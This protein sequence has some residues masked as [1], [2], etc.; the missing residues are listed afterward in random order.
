MEIDKDFTGSLFMPKKRFHDLVYSNLIKFIREK[1][2]ILRR[3][4]HLLFFL[5]H[6]GCQF[7]WNSLYCLHT[8]N[9]CLS[10]GQ[11]RL[12]SI[13]YIKREGEYGKTSRQSGSIGI[14]Y[15]RTRGY[16]DYFGSSAGSV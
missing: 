1:M 4:H 2:T 10:A 9:I 16:A 6:I 14:G 15:C 7:F 11:K 5:F 12:L 3:N 8:E 13:V